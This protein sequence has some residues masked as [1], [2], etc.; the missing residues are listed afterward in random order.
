[1]SVV[2]A[3]ATSHRAA[4]V[5]GLLWRSVAGTSSRRCEKVGPERQQRLEAPRRPRDR[6]AKGAREQRAR[7]SGARETTTDG[8]LCLA[9]SRTAELMDEIVS[10][11][12]HSCIRPLQQIGGVALGGS[13][14]PSST[15][16]AP[17]ARDASGTVPCGPLAM[18]LVSHEIVR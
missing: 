3:T 18:E 12:V 14:I 2:G 7:P 4:A 8:R 15:R 13:A 9:A 17:S 11:A 16:W 10:A 5:Y 1:M 6:R